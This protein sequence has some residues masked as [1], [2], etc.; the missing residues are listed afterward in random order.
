MPS[1]L[2]PIPKAVLVVEDDPAV[3]KLVRGFLEAL[4]C[5]VT[6]VPDGAKALVALDGGKFELVVLDLML[7]ESSGYDVLE[8][9]RARKLTGTPVIMMSARGLPEDRAHAEELGAVLYLIKPFTRADFTRA[10]KMVLE[11]RPA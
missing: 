11:G 8:A 5:A 4:G 9:M 2:T 6:E 3:R 10:V 7:P 1:K